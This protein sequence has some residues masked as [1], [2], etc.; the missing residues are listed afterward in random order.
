[1]KWKALLPILVFALVVALGREGTITSHCPV[2]Y[3]VSL[4][5]GVSLGA[6]GPRI[7]PVLSLVSMLQ[8]AGIAVAISPSLVAVV[9]PP[10]FTPTRV[11]QV[12]NH[13]RQLGKASGRSGKK[14]E[15]TYWLPIE[16]VSAGRITSK[17][18]RGA[19]FFGPGRR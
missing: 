6:P 3:C 5:S 12:A 18:T 13:I 14:F 4:S 8:L 2:T 9:G 1:M 15:A 7:Q 19:A 11:L 10:K 17:M 16:S